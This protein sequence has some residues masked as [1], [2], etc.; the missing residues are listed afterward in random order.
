MGVFSW[1]IGEVHRALWLV[2]P[3]QG[4]R[5]LGLNGTTDRGTICFDIRTVVCVK[6][7]VLSPEGRPCKHRSEGEGSLYMRVYL[8]SKDASGNGYNLIEERRQRI[9]SGVVD[10]QLREW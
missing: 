9:S 2:T 6:D 3:S 7:I 5:E 1:R 10:G 8:S 4:K